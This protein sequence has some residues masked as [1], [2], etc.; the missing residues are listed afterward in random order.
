M[1]L[2]Y[3]V[4]DNVC[5]LGPFCTN[6]ASTSDRAKTFNGIRFVV[7]KLHIKGHV[8]CLDTHHPDLFPE[9]AD[10][11]TVVCEQVNFW[12]SKYKY[13]LKHMNFY[14]YNFFLYVIFNEY[15]VI[16][17]QDTIKIAD[18]F[19]LLKSKGVKQTLNETD[20]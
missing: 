9:L 20:Y 6:K 12:L 15:N 1:F 19:H 7:D 8:A 17:L 10:I 11:N 5:H 13:I 4:Y 16:K 18:T 3:C 14:R 2:K